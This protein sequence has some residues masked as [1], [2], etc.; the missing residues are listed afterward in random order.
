M[1]ATR[2]VPTTIPGR[3]VRLQPVQRA[4]LPALFLAIGHPVVFAGGYGGGASGYRG[5]C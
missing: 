3:S 5:K 1:T 4:H 2:P